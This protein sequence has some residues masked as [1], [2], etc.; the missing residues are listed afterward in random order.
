MQLKIGRG[1]R[2]YVTESP[3]NLPLVDAKKLKA[4]YVN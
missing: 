2:G 1:G 4:N 3:C